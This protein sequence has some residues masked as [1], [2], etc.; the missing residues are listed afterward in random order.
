MV[1]YL[2]D[3]RSFITTLR[4]LPYSARIP[5]ITD[6]TRFWWSIFSLLRRLLGTGATATHFR[7]ASVQILAR[8]LSHRKMAFGIYPRAD[9]TSLSPSLKFQ[10]SEA[11]RG[12]L[13]VSE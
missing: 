2:H 13:A 8:P 5:R 9:L 11:I 4:A 12:H 10:V 7:Q 3:G 6:H 1:G